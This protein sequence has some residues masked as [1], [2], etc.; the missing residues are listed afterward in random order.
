MMAHN[1]TTAER[2]LSFLHMMCPPFFFL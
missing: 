1:A 2:I